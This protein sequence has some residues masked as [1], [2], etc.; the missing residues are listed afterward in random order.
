MTIFGIIF[1]GILLL[2]A[3]VWPF[4]YEFSEKCCWW[5][6]SDYCKAVGNG[7]IKMGMSIFLLLFIFVFALALTY[8]SDGK[9]DETSVKTVPIHSIGVTNSSSVGGN[10]FLGIGSVNGE[11]YP[12]YQ[13]YTLSEDNRYKLHQVNANN[14]DIV[15][16]DSIAP[17][18]QYCDS[19]I[20]TP[21]IGLL[22]KEEI[23]NRRDMKDSKGTIYIPSNSIVADF[24]IDL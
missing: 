2:A 22:F 18:I 10:F 16:T 6:F 12:V 13:F 20:V 3:I 5:H 1:F 21:P 9:I 24:T 7:L 23:K 4:V 17:S 19:A 8:C 15:C 11:S 14:Y